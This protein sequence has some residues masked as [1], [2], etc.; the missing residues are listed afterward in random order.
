VQADA[1]DA[2][3]QLGE[4]YMGWG[5]LSEAEDALKQVIVP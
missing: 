4:T 5:K 3:L 2:S 1:A